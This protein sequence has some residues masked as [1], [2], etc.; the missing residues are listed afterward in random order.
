[1]TPRPAAALLLALLCCC[2]SVALGANRYVSPGGEDTGSCTDSKSPCRTINYCISRMSAGDTCNVADGNYT[3]TTD[4]S[5]MQSVACVKSRNCTAGNPCTLRSEN[6]HG[7]MIN[8]GAAPIFINNSDHWKIEQFQVGDSAS[9]TLDECVRASGGDGLEITDVDCW[10]DD[11]LGQAVRLI[12]RN[13]DTVTVRKVSVRTI[14]SDQCVMENTSDREAIEIRGDD[15]TIE[16]S[17]FEYGNQIGNIRDYATNITIRRNVFK[18]FWSHGLTIRDGASNI[19]IENNIFGADPSSKCSSLWS[20]NTQSRGIDVYEA[21][22][23]TIRNNTF[24]G[25]GY[26]W[27]V[28]FRNYNQDAQVAAGCTSDVC[29]NTNIKFYNNLLYDIKPTGGYIRWSNGAAVTVSNWKADGNLY[30]SG[31]DSWDCDDQGVSGF[32]NWQALK[33]FNSGSPDGRGTTAQPT[34]VD[35]GSEDYRPA[36]A[37]AAQV[38][39]GLSGL[40]AEGLA[41]C[42]SEDFNGNPRSGACDIGAFEFISGQSNPG[43]SRVWN[44]RR[45]DTRN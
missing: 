35:Y 39:S 32:N 42:A 31:P 4:C 25:H 15:I 12:F 37:S 41:Y 6:L 30:N 8:A 44:V 40:D 17:R 23:L 28:P 20:S 29:D 27:R 33:C 16:D 11:E 13:H 5:G 34:F 10:H 36:S 1:M 21:S 45:T 19:L 9:S 22:N 7:A 24:V 2:A 38:N 14:P 43:P 26:G 18:N 3:S